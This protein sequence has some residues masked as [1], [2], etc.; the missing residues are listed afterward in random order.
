MGNAEV[1]ARDTTS[2][3]DF[4]NTRIVHVVRQFAPMVGGLEDVVLNLAKSQTK[5]FANVRVVTLDRLFTRPDERL[6]VTESIENIEVIRIPYRGSKRYPIAPKVLQHL[7]DADLV[8]VHAI[9]FFFDALAV[10]QPLHR[11]PLV[12]TTHGGFFHT[13]RNAGLKKLWFNTVTRFSASRYRGI[14]CCGENDFELFQPLAPDR[15]RLIE[16]GVDLT[17]FAGAASTK[18]VKRLVT[19]GR[20]SQNKRLERVLDMLAAVRARD[21]GFE[22]DII[23]S[24]SDLSVEDL[25]RGVESRGLGGAV[26]IHVGLTNDEVRMVFSGVSL[27]VSASDYEGFGLVLIEALSAGLIPVVH[28]NAAFRSLAGH[29]PTVCLTDFSAPKKAADA[30][31]ETFGHLVSDEDLR[32]RAQ[33]SSRRHGW[34]KTARDYEEFYAAA[35]AG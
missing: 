24:P 17:K 12:A 3:N 35:L 32:A 33:Q 7:K 34:E 29:H 20:F 5:R 13:D 8:H 16:N 19:V 27:F 11:R 15:V 25:E 30:V 2:G 4:S 18:P 9:D 22:L 26:R 23:G 6:P 21:E 1:E 31:L 10:T 14:A 28:E